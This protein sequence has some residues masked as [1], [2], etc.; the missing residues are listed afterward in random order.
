MFIDK[1]RPRF[2]K[3][4]FVGR[5]LGS[6]SAFLVGSSNPNDKDRAFKGGRG[7]TIGSEGSVRCTLANCCNSSVMGNN[8][9][10]DSCICSK[11]VKRRLQILRDVYVSRSGGRELI[12]MSCSVAAGTG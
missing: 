7:E 6:C 9:F 2:D 8:G 5:S 3:D 10:G 11:A 12:S 1:A 4:P